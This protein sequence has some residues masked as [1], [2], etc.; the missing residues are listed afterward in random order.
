LSKNSTFKIVLLTHILFSFLYLIFFQNFFEKLLTIPII[1][2]PSFLIGN[3]FGKLRN[4]N[5]KIVNLYSKFIIAFLFLICSIY[6]I[7]DASITLGLISLP[8]VVFLY[9]LSFFSITTKC[10]NLFLKLGEMSYGIYI[11]A[12]PVENLFRLIFKNYITGYIYLL[13][14]FLFLVLIVLL[15]EQVSKK[16]I[17]ANFNKIL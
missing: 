10:N 2:L 1:H 4:R 6:Y 3:Y 8:I 14:Y 7:K 16:F 13:I 12:F 9:Y 11:L 5:V 15:I 17:Y